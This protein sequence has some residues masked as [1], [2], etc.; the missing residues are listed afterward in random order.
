MAGM[1]A[2]LTRITGR[3]VWV[4]CATSKTQK[5]GASPVFLLTFLSSSPRSRS[6][7]PAKMGFP[8]RP[9]KQNA[10]EAGK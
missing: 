6:R 9:R 2:V 5:R 10:R 8:G 7:L 4:T 3:D 1:G